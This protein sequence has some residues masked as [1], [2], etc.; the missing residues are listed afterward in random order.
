M[1]LLQ[2]IHCIWVRVGL[3][4]RVLMPTAAHVTFRPVG[5][6]ADVLQTHDG[7]VATTRDDATVFTPAAA[8]SS[9][10]MLLPGCPVDRI[11]SFLSRCWSG[12]SFTRLE[13]RKN[14]SPMCIPLVR[15]FPPASVYHL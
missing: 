4:L 8:R 5:V 14:F 3:T 2:P 7:V 9:D 11:A 13:S 1:T 6:A 12:G 10:L 15:D